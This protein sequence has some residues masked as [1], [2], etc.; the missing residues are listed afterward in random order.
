M[1]Y[2]EMNYA[3]H[4]AISVTIYYFITQNSYFMFYRFA[5]RQWIAIN[6]SYVFMFLTQ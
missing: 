2:D 4:K 1:N 6:D 5:T 3:I